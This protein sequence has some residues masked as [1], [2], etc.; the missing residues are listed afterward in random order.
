M[1]GLQ[2]QDDIEAQLTSEESKQKN[3]DKDKRVLPLDDKECSDCHSGS[4]G[5]LAC[6]ANN[7]HEEGKIDRL[8]STAKDQKDTHKHL[9]P[10]KGSILIRRSSAK[11]ETSF[12]ESM[13]CSP[14]ECAICLQDYQVGDDIC[15]SR[16]E[17][18]QHAF[19]IDCM[20]RWLLYHDECPICREE[21]L[22]S[23]SE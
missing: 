16:N 2:C 15:W 6:E 9:P 13:D 10:R 14:T 11:G 17:T 7:N 12:S 8:A 18:C 1:R 19:H 20:T 5:S 23:S 22:H 21:Y 3:D 4:S